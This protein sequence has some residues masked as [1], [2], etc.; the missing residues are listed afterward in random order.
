MSLL[1]L[2]KR[3]STG[4]PKNVEQYFN[5][6]AP[7]YDN[8][9]FTTSIALTVASL[10]RVNN[11]K[12]TRLD[13]SLSAIFACAMLSIAS[14]KL[15]CRTAKS[16]AFS[17]KDLNS[18]SAK[19]FFYLSSIYERISIGPNQAGTF[20]YSELLPALP[21]P[22]LKESKDRF[23]E[24]LKVIEPAKF[25][26]LKKQWEHFIETEAPA[27]HRKLQM[28][29]HTQASYVEEIWI[30]LAYLQTRTALPLCHSWWGTDIDDPKI[31]SES[32]ALD[33]TA[34]LIYAAVEMRE[35]LREESYSP[36]VMNKIPADMEPY[37][38]LFWYQPYSCRRVRHDKFLP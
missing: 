17:Y 24:F 37:K 23:L 33:R 36:V 6:P 26:E 1:D 7:T 3:H 16:W 13:R 28:L 21:L 15:V 11:Q 30:H 35:K 2:L 31:L 29:W 22:S 34:R 27:L 12:L 4:Y 38:L 9:K 32:E 18:L 10:Y 8:I 19:S 25:Q 20:T 5:K 14:S